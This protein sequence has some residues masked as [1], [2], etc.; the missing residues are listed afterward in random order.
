MGQLLVR[1]VE[2]AVIARLKE[3]AAAHGRSVEAEHREILRTTLED[4]EERRREREAL[5]ERLRRLQAETA[6]RGGQT[7]TELIREDRDSR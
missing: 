4:P 5:I 2:D 6:G 7:G 1:G 3:R